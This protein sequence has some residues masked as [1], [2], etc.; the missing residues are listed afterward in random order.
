MQKLAA[1]AIKTESFFPKIIAFFR[2]VQTPAIKRLP[3]EIAMGKQAPVA[4]TAI[5]HK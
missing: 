5:A 3:L 1:N 4:I 2:F